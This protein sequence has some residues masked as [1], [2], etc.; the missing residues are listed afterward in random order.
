MRRS[1]ELSWPVSLTVPGA[2]LL[3]IAALFDPRAAAANLLLAGIALLWFGLAGC[4]AVALQYGRLRPQREPLRAGA[5][6]MAALLP[7]GAVALALALLGAPWLYAWHTEPLHGGFK[8]W[9][10]NRPFFLARAGVYL[11]VWLALGHVLSG[12]SRARRAGDS[13]A[14][15]RRH[16][17]A[18]VLFF[19]LGGLT[20][21]GASIDWIKS[22]EPHWVSTIFG[23]YQFGGLCAGGTALLI[24]LTARRQSDPALLHDLG[25]LL[26][27]FCCLWVYLWFCQYLLIW[28]VN[29]P[30][31]SVYYVDRLE[32]GWGTLFY[33][34]AVCSWLVPFLVLLPARCK[35]SATVLTRV[36]VVVMLGRWL[37]LYLAIAPGAVGTRPAPGLP[38]LGA[39][40]LVIGLVGLVARRGVGNSRPVAQHHTT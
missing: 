31:E 8:A 23:L 1:A 20:L 7:I 4:G 19:Y 40:L 28:Y 6:T 30:E 3:T 25:Q 12:L 22:L 26:F 10:L 37:D 33:A 16:T 36:A 39:A 14:L 27:A 29:I 11:A 35:R 5:E 32:G 9:W 13:G 18:A 21:L 2:V 17:L 38:E 15:Q 34:N 24:L